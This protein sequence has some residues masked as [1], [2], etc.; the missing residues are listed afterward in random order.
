MVLFVYF[1]HL[2]THSYSPRQFNPSNVPQNLRILFRV[3]PEDGLAATRHGNLFLLSNGWQKKKFAI[4]NALLGGALQKRVE[5]V[6]FFTYLTIT[7]ELNN[8]FDKKV[9]HF[10]LRKKI[11][12]L[13]GLLD[14]VKKLV[15]HF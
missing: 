4:K 1:Y 5:K 14:Y 13:E 15:K 9:L 3:R 8:P 6:V 11:A 12:L 10:F 2:I 7:L